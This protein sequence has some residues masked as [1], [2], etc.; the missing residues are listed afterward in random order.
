MASRLI[1]ALALLTVTY[2]LNKYTE[3]TVEIEETGEKFKETVD[4]DF[5]NGFEI[6]KVPAHGQQLE[7]VDVMKDLRMGF[8][9][10]KV[11]RLKHCYVMNL[12]ND[13]K[14]MFEF[15]TGIFLSRGHIP[16]NH[17][18]KVLE[19]I[20]VVGDIPPAWNSA[21][22]KAFCG[23][24]KIVMAQ[25]FAGKADMEK[26]AVQLAKDSK[27]DLRKRAVL[28]E[29]VA[30]DNKSTMTIST[31]TDTTKLKANCRL[32]TKYC[33]YIVSCPLQMSSGG[34]N[35]GSKHRLD[36]IVCCDYACNA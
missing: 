26:I 14:N 20:L 33:T 36:S 10:A 25:A 21:K 9:A 23:D 24:N 6:V 29:F 1:I 12:E 11:H 32:R 30:C 31:C 22:L 3:V 4:F 16:K 34:F 13:D 17:I 35:C 27:K 2:A 7:E 15:E 5:K 18:K 8:K 19:N 28:R